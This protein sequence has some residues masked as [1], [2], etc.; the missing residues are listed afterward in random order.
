MSMQI[1]LS[2]QK[3]GQTQQHAYTRGLLHCLPR[4][5]GGGTGDLPVLTRDPAWLDEG[6]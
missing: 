3:N 4:V 1:F 2:A 5:E 6:G